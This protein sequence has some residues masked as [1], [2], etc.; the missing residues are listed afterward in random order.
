MAHHAVVDEKDANGV[1]FADGGEQHG[2][3]CI[4]GDD[5]LFKSGHLKSLPLGIL[6]ERQNWEESTPRRLASRQSSAVTKD[7][8][9]SNR[10]R[11]ERVTY[12]DVDHPRHRIARDDYRAAPLPFVHHEP[13]PQPD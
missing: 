7:G 6:S 13:F 2:H 5:I 1:W 3:A 9:D 11:A 12:R 4:Q 10:P 8:A